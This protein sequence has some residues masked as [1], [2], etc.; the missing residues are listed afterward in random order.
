MTA[1][2]ETHDLVLVPLTPIHVGGG[3]EARLA[4][5]DY[6]LGN[7]VVER[8]AVRAV[9]K[10]LPDAERAQWIARMARA[11]GAA[12]ANDM[13]DALRALQGKAT[14]AEVLERI[15]IAAESARAVDLGGEGHGR[16]NQIDA[17]FR[18]GG[19]PCLPGSSVK[20]MLRT[21]WAEAC[22]DRFDTPRLPALAEWAGLRPRDRARHATQAVGTLYAQASDKHAQDTDPF[23]D[24]TVADAPLPDGA[25]RIDRVVTWKRQRTDGAP[26]RRAPAE[27]NFESRGE[28]HRERLR[29][30]ADG[31]APPTIRIE[32]GLRA[33]AIRSEGARLDATRRPRPDR[34]PDS[35]GT[36]LAALDA[37][38]APLWRR[39]AEEKFFAGPNGDR[40]RSAL[41]LFADFPRGG[42]R[43]EAALVRL[44]WA[45]HAEA[46]S[47]A[48]LRRIEI[49][50]PKNRSDRRID[51]EGTARHVVNLAGHPLPF[52]W[53][54]LIRAEV[55]AQKRPPSWFA[56]PSPRTTASGP[57]AQATGRSPTPVD[58]RASSSLGQQLLYR[59]GQRVL[60]DGEEATLLEDVT[61]AA[62]PGDEVQVRLHGDTEVIRVHEIEGPA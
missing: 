54:L 50:N 40:L 13:R 55:W 30:V 1:Q 22:A 41:A 27:W 24:V 32:I 59:K 4:P 46:K 51:V 45:S 42:D 20:G 35:L 11:Q 2:F 52:G 29:S 6:R 26:G 21:A 57:A 9:L 3:E 17:F 18:A 44:G 56:P 37:H 8:V 60:V 31:G 23:R 47:I 28:I 12:A 33:S 7:G 34:T 58:P 25:T 39:E 15:L 36:L 14:D 43:P 53:A 19:R 16:R 38:H 61:A 48:G 62:R 49:I 10:R 5:E